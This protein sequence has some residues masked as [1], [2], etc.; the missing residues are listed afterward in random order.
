MTTK[1]SGD[2]ISTRAWLRDIIHGD[3]YILRGVSALEFLQMFVGYIGENHIEVYAKARG[4]Y[5]NVEYKVVGDFHENEYIK[6]GNT[7]CTTFNQTIN[8][9]LSDFDHSDEQALTEAVCNYFFE[10]NESFD[11]LKINPENRKTFQQ[12]MINAV[13]YASGG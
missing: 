10:H 3:D 5:E 11:G 13:N 9:M 7:L 12:I 1:T 4:I 6:I 8:D 2:Y